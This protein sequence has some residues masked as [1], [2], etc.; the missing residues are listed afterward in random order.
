MN[1]G[2]FFSERKRRNVSKV[3]VFYIIG[4]CLLIGLFFLARY[5]ASQKKPRSAKTLE[6]SIAVLPF[7]NLSEDKSK[8]YFATGIQ[9]EILTRLS[10]L[11]ELKV[12]SRTSTA[13]YQSKP[14]NIGEIAKQ[15]GVAHL[16]EG[17]VQKVGEQVRVNVQLINAQ[18]DAHIW[19]E[20]Y[21]RKLTDIFAVETEI[22]R[23]IAERLQAKL[24]GH[25]QEALALKSTSNPGACDAYLRGLAAES[26]TLLSV[27]PLQKAISFYK[28]AVKLD[29]DF[30][31]AWA[32]LAIASATPKAPWNTRKSSS[33]TRR[34]LCWHW[35][36]TKMTS[37][38][39]TSRPAKL[40]FVLPNCCL[41]T[42]RSQFR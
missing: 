5:T 32:P 4:A 20:T 39:I 31:M 28:R 37:C 41:G 7:E 8:A 1:P 19:A 29:P 38:A 25:E 15:L 3:A 14:G 13:Q 11:N 18:N 40:F 34:K 22:A 21:D 36:S 24:S 33:R 35:Q 23:S 30:A 26:E 9:D 6:K 10:R 2:S 16:L 17:S 27:Y 42:A 12:I